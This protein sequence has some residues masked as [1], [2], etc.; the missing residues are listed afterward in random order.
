MERHQ[1]RCYSKPFA[2]SVARKAS[3]VETSL[4]M[5]FESSSR[6]KRNRNVFVPSTSAL[7][8]YAQGERIYEVSAPEEIS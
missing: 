4:P 8:A 3:E 7:C 5:R 6:W 1:A 2:L